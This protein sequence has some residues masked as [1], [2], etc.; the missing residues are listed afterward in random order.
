MTV[1]ELKDHLDALISLELLEDV[2]V[3]VRYGD[4]SYTIEEIEVGLVRNDVSIVVST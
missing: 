1:G 3:Y 2:E 4:V